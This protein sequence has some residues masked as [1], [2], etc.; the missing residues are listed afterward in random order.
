MAKV[1]PVVQI[2]QF[3]T[4]NTSRDNAEFK[5]LGAQQHSSDLRY[6]S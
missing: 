3:L 1:N 5:N 4:G 2:G 6:L